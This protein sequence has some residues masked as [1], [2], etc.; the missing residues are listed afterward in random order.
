[1]SD[2]QGGRDL[3]DF[4]QFTDKVTSP[5]VKDV[6]SDTLDAFKKASDV[7]FLLISSEKSAKVRFFV[8]VVSLII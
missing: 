1:V 7:S 5:A 8:L 2:Y 3:N 6:T 4:K